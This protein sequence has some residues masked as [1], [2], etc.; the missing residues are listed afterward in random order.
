MHRTVPSRLVALL[1]ST[2]LISTTILSGATS[3]ALAD[4]IP[5]FTGVIDSPITGATLGA[6]QPFTINGWLVDRSTDA[7]VGVDLIGVTAVQPGQQPIDLGQARLAVARPDVAAALN[8]PNWN[9]AGYRLDAPGLPAGTYTLA[10]N[11][12]TTR[13][14]VNQTATLKVGELDVTR[15]T[16]Y[17]FNVQAPSSMWPMLELLH[18]SNFDWAL[19]GA[20]RK[21]TPIVWAELPRGVYGQYSSSNNQIKLSTVLQS[22]SL[23]ARTTFLAHELTHLNDDLNGVLG[24]MTGSACYDAETRAFVNEANLWSMLFGSKGK[25]GADAIEAQENTKM[26]AFVGNTHFADLVVRTTASYVKQCGTD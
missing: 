22:T 19:A 18:R 26:W 3:V 20:S 12:H 24:D 8:N 9:D 2:F 7:N 6:G 10:I 25:A 14:W 15:W 17:G 1:A 16:A 11:A 13:G 5:S 4:E 21:P 23:E